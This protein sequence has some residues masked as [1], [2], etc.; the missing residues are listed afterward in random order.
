MRMTVA[1]VV[2]DD[3]PIL[4]IYQSFVLGHIV[5]NQFAC[6]YESNS[7]DVTEVVE[8]YVIFNPRLSRQ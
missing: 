6:S 8:R 5:D 3:R 7:N 1:A 2:P 4:S